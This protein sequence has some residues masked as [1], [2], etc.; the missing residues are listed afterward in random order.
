MKPSATIWVALLLSTFAVIGQSQSASQSPTQPMAASAH[1]ASSS[2]C[3]ISMS[4]QQGSGGVLR[5]ADDRAKGVGQTL[6]LFLI[7]PSSKQ[8]RAAQVTVSGLTAKGRLAQAQADKASSN[9][10]DVEKTLE[11]TFSTGAGEEIVADLW[12]PGLTA[13][14]SIHLDAVTYTD[15]STWKLPA[16]LACRAVPDPTMLIN[17]R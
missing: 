17:N 5:D 2:D 1:Y 12:A 13:V 8:I 6:H 10:P 3:P 14:H 9:L 15:G 4:A 11:I 16:G 7:N